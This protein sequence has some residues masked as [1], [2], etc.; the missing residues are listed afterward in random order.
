[1]QVIQVF[2]TAVMQFHLHNI[3]M[4]CTMYT[5]TQIFMFFQYEHSNYIYILEFGAMYMNHVFT[6][7]TINLNN[8]DQFFLLC[9]I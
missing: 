2:N 1:M 7:I 6:T 4:Q 8:G 9:P 3:S 5:M